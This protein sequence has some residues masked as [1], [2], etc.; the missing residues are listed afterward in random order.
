MKKNRL[1]QEELILLSFHHILQKE[2]KCSY[3]ELVK[4]CFVLFPKVFALSEYPKWP[5]SLKLARSLR[6]LREKRLIKG[7]PATFYSL[8]VLGEKVVNKLVQNKGVK[9]KDIKEST[10]TRSPALRILDE[11]K[12]SQDF[13]EFIRNKKKFEANEMRIRG[14]VGYTLETPRRKL[15]DFLIYLRN[16]AKESRNDKIYKYL[17]VYLDY[18]DKNS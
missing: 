6:K 7:S 11:M 14:L 9:K 12:D 2:K 5:D 15:K 10:P 17:S 16:I 4:T 18:L 13:L 3:N 8:T 1:T